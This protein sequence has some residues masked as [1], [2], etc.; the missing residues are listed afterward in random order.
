[1][2]DAKGTVARTYMYMDLTFPGRGV[3]SNKNEKLFA[4]WDKMYPAKGWECERAQL[5]KAIQKKSNP[6]LE[7]RCETGAQ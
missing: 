1:M 2:D 6:I 7:S 4:A 3:I 5:I